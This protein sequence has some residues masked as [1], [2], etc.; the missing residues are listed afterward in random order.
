M[1]Q[2]RLNKRRSVGTLQR[3]IPLLWSLQRWIDAGLVVVILWGLSIIQQVP[4]TAPYTMLAVLTAV[5]TP[6]L[7][8]AAGLYRAESP[9]SGPGALLGGWSLVVIFLLFVG[10]I[11]EAFS[12]FSWLLL[13]LWIVVAPIVLLTLRFCLKRYLRRHRKS[14]LNNRKAVIAGT[15]ELSAQLARQLQANPELGFQF[16]GYFAES[17]DLQGDRIQYRPLIGRLEELPE[18]V[19]RHNIDVVYIALSMQAEDTIAQLINELQDTTASVYFV[20]NLTLFQLMQARI[21]T[22]QGM[23]LVSVWEVPFSGLQSIAKRLMD[24]VVSA[25]ALILLSPV[26]LG[27][28]IAIKLTSP[29]TILFKQ[30]RYGL[31][32]R[33]ITVY[34]F[35]SMAVAEN[36]ADVKQAQK[37]DPR[38][39]PLGAILRRT[40]LDE[41][42][43]FIN[44]LQGRMSIVG[45]RPHAVAH[46]EHYRKLV[47]GYMLRHLVKP[48]ITGWAQVNGFRGE[49]ETLDKMEQRIKYD[50]HYLN[51]WSLLL[52]IKIILRTVLVLTGQKNA[53]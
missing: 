37:N 42:P 7:F 51:H 32:G 1:S 28:A 25:I 3:W 27:I 14:G 15:G 29:G 8:N 31:S 35:R 45:P 41:L 4:W 6:S 40:S 18:F 52:D 2:P 50:L 21:H 23:P 34:K 9:G 16:Q 19:R 48:G 17:V 53:Y 20:P 49:T 36:G 38:V 5:I 24:I 26:M 39:T 12:S 13:G 30:H 22:L 46:N 43:Q 11:T 47:Q 44:V 10:L 33:E